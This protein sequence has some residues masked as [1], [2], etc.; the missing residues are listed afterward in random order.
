MLTKQQ[1][2][3]MYRSNQWGLAA[4]YGSRWCELPPCYLT[5]RSGKVVGGWFWV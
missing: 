5:K 4:V 3:K 2:V 1:K